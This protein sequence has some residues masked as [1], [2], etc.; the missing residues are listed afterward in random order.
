MYRLLIVLYIFSSTVFATENNQI[1]VSV[2]KSFL[3]PPLIG[4]L[5][6]YYV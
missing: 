6:H 5:F 3:L 4:L 1:K 2:R